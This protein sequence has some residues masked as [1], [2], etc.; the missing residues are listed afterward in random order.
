MFDIP[1]LIEDP[2]AILNPDNA[3]SLLLPPAERP[4]APPDAIPLEAPPERFDM[5]LLD[6]LVA[7]ADEEGTKLLEAPNFPLSKWDMYDSWKS[8]NTTT[9]SVT[10]SIW[11]AI[12]PLPAPVLEAP[13]ELAAPALEPEMLLYPDEAPALLA[14]PDIPPPMLLCP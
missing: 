5:P 10:S 3:W 14:A 2:D 13:L 11:E 4:L 8:T 7:A 9:E 12:L 1:L 6:A